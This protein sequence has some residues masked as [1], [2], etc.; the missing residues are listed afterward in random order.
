MTKKEAEDR[1]QK[2]RETIAHHRYQYHV[3][4]RQEISE[5]AL[6]SLKHELYELE[7]LHP[8][9]IAPDSPTQRVG[10]EPL[11]KFRKVQH[12]MRMLSMEDVFSEEEFEKWYKRALDRSGEPKLELYGMPKLD[13]LAIS[14]EYGNGKLLVGATRGNGLVGEDV[15]SNV[16]TIESVPLS[17][18]T[19]HEK[20]ISNFLKRHP[21]LDTGRVQTFLRRPM[22]KL[23]VRGEIY[24]PVKAF[25]KM[26]KKRAKAGEPTF[27]NPRNVSAGSIRQL[28][29][30]IAASRPLD[31]FAWDLLNDIGQISHDQE[32]ELLQL[33][34]FKTSPESK[35]LK[36]V[37]EAEAFWQA[38]GR[39][40][41]SLPFWIDGAVFR[42]NENEIQ[43]GL[44]IVG[45]TPRGL[46]AWKLPAEE[47][48]TIVRDVEWN[49]GRTG[50]LTPVAIVEP[51]FV[52]GTTVQHASLHNMDE[53]ER[54]G[55][56]IGDT[57][58]LIKAGD[59][60][61]KVIRVLEELRPKDAKTIQAPK[62]CPIC[63]SPVDRKKEGD[64][65]LVCT[66]KNC[67]AKER[68]RIAYAA[69]AFEIDGLGE[70]IVE[71]LLD[72][73]LISRAPD[74]FTV[75]VD[76]LKEL[77]RFAEVSANKLVA[78]IQSKKTI[79]LDKF[80]IALGIPN[81]GEETA[82]D[83]AQAF[84]S[85]ERVQNVSKEE[86]IM[87]DGIGDVVADGLVEFFTS[88]H[89]QGLLKDYLENGILVNDAEV[90]KATTLSGR[91]FVLTGTLESLSR[92][93]AKQKVID[94]GGSVSGSVSKKID[95]VV[96]GENPGSKAEKAKELGV[97]ILSESQFLRMISK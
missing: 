18:R 45:K 74:L 64:V 92:D 4:D 41:E 14:L 11:P 15:T 86:W 10:G 1:I 76:E 55:L 65:A 78:E 47:T 50:A 84:G 94:L 12:E 63:D 71:Q 89:G 61:P 20:E 91:T 53:I 51:T 3:L 29:P 70:K 37:K 82:R 35:V 44:G 23:V 81:V 9:L 72:V 22:K 49:V 73:G 5:A 48:T 26:N 57:V 7:Q 21:K 54:L 40:R 19:P 83:I 97:S 43:K 6:D 58:I 52:A 39:K 62:T 90:P 24:M 88:E 79:P 32:M 38:L 67:F 2:L 75:T 28:D 33:L 13:G 31:F 95:Y 77:E 69:K 96:V 16:R 17:L 66:N 87:V 60:I 93:E 80:L 46:V 59:I 56:K 8:D 68:E 27:A 85:L 34:G 30:K 25:E 42:I 36:G